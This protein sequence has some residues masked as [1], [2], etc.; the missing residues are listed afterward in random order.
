MEAG[1]CTGLGHIMLLRDFWVLDQDWE[2]FEAF[3][4]AMKIIERMGLPFTRLI[5]TPR[6]SSRR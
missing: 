2:G 4:E 1:N 3:L 5:P 6:K